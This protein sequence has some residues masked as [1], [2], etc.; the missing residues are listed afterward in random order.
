MDSPLVSV[1]IPTYNRFKYLLNAIKSV[2]EQTYKNI[3]IIIVNDCSIQEE[4]YNYKFENCVVIHL[5]KNSKKR[6]GHA[7]PG[8]FQRTQGMKIASGEYIAFLDDDDYW[9]PDK[10]EKQIIAMTTSKCLISCTDGFIGAGLYDKTKKYRIYNK[11]KYQ[12]TIK[13]IFNRKGKGE[14]MRNGFPDIWTKEF[15]N[16]HN[17]CIASSVIIHKSIINKIGYFSNN[18]WA[19]D[20][21]YWKRVIQHSNLIYLNEPLLYWDSGHGYGQNY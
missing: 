7:S 8:G 5:D 1:I 6:F 3:E 10:L 16:V 21:E 12:N 13:G 18:L 15:L 20:Y 14:L 9:L 17:C 11:E 4:Y 2:K 19:P